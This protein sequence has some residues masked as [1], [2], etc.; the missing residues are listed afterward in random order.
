MDKVGTVILPALFAAHGK[1][2]PLVR[3][4]IARQTGSDD[5]QESVALVLAQSQCNQV[6]LSQEHR[7][8]VFVFSSVLQR[9]SLSS[10]EDLRG[11]LL[12]LM[13]LA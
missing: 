13:L 1:T 2:P 7:L 4:T 9:T 10:A 6:Q 12:L 5:L 3:A 8:R 11:A